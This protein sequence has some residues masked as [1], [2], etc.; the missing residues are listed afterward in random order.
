MRRL[1]RWV[2]DGGQVLC[3]GD[4]VGAMLLSGVSKGLDGHWRYAAADM[5]MAACMAMLY[6]LLVR[7]LSTPTV[8]AAPLVSREPAIAPVQVMLAPCVVEKFGEAWVLRECHTLNRIF[9]EEGDTRCLA[10]L[11]DSEDD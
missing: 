6:R 10:L 1:G 11:P 5:A 3:L 2:V 9:L 4:I 8:A 7:Y